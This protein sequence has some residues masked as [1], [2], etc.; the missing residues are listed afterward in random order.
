MKWARSVSM[1]AVFACLAVPA[2]A[3]PAAPCRDNAALRYWMAFAEMENPPADSDVAK[4]LGAVA[5]GEAPWDEG[6]API[7]DR[8]RDALATLH[9]GARLSFCDWG[10]EY[11][12]LSAAPIANIARARTLARLNVLQGMRLLRAGRAAESVDAWLAGVRFSRDIAADGPWL[13]ALVAGRS[14][15]AHLDVLSGAVRDAKLDAP[16]R[17]RVAQEIAA[18]PEAGF[19]WSVAARRELE[20]TAA[21]L[22]TLERADDPLRALEQDHQLI[23]SAKPDET[24]KKLGLRVAQLSDREAVRAALRRARAFNDAVRP[25]VVA[26]MARPHAQSADAVREA[27]DRLAQDP[28]VSMMSPSLARLN[29]AR[30]DVV[31]ARAELLALVA[32]R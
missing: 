26:A 30:G 17:A 25:A 22:A 10:Y 3:A 15:R 27:S 29:D 19:D 9:R 14:V 13:A 7:L 4:R 21:I 6:L 23:S 16:L 20:G 2:L 8:N 5:E 12:M 11:E 1:L 18:L 28:T 31:K 24:A 32:G